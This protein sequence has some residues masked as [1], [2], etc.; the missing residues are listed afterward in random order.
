MA[1]HISNNERED[2]RG[3][4]NEDF[5]RVK[6]FKWG[7]ALHQK[8]ILSQR[9]GAN[10]LSAKGATVNGSI[11]LKDHFHWFETQRRRICPTHIKQSSSTSSSVENQTIIVTLGRQAQLMNAYKSH[12]H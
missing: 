12:S 2:I 6:F 8:G 5:E 4:K 3:D 9:C 1:M 11:L 10:L 7:A